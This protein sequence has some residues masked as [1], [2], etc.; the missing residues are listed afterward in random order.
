METT[1]RLAR[2]SLIAIGIVVVLA[3]L[4][5]A[6]GIFAPL[7]LALVTGVVLSPLSD[8]WE[9]R[10]FSPAWG[11]MIGLIV[12][13]LA[14]GAIVL[15][16]QPVIARL[17]AQ[18]PKVWAD[19]QD[20]VR[21]LRGL[22]RG[23]SDVSDGVAK[24]IAPDSG[25]GPPA[26]SSE[27]SMAM[28]SVATAL[29]YAPAILSQILIFAG[30]LFFFLLTRSEIY[31]W[32]AV[33]LTDTGSRV[34]LGQRLRRA[35]RNVARY[36]LTITLI[37][38]GL[39]TLTA[40]VFETLG[41]RDAVVWGVLAFLMNFVVYLGPVIFMV[42]LLFVGVAEFDGAMSVAPAFSYMILNGIEGQF[43]TPS[44]IGRNMSVNPLLVFLSLIFGLWL[45]G[46]IG[47]IV[48][49]PLLLWVLVLNDEIKE[50]IPPP[51]RPD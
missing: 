4:D 51:P 18:A 2:L 3:A 17:V 39:G 15:T 49:I 37:N 1:E 33:R 47:G 26:A 45:W 27:E 28:P 11:A 31:S 9:K 25:N 41:V 13:L 14:V 43:V 32:V 7:C 22:M 24:A 6:E 34:A 21:D 46:P 29:M 20:V 8:F 23:L 19:M 30:A 48:A 5:E 10:G 16:F 40:L 38:A 42:V 36:F 35:E 44:L 12:A 50:N